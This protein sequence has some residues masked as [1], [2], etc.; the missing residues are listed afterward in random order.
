MS[1][2]FLV[3]ASVERNRH[4]I[5][6]EKRIF[7]KALRAGQMSPAGIGIVGKALRTGQMSPARIGIVGKA[8]RAEPDKHCRNRRRSFPGKPDKPRN[9]RKDKENIKLK[10]YVKLK[11]YLK[12][13]N[14]KLTARTAAASLC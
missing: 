12:K 9:N 7:G 10:K 2:D 13:K 3:D 4:K 1:V 11:K 5:L 6:A 8:F 14:F